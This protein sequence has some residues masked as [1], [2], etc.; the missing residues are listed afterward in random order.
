MGKETTFSVSEILLIS[1]RVIIRQSGDIKKKC[2]VDGVSARVYPVIYL[3]KKVSNGN[4]K[5]YH[6]TVCLSA[7]WRTHR[8]DANPS[9]SVE[10]ENQGVRKIDSPF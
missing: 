8:T 5:Y 9:H 6:F 7:Y 2:L 4:N 3:F 1:Y 10:R